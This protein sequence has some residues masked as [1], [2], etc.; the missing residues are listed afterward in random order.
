MVLLDSDVMVDRLRQDAPALAGLDTLGDDE[1]LLPGFVAMEL[2]QGCTHR[3]GRAHLEKALAP[4]TVVWP[5]PAVC[6]EA[7]WCSRG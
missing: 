2:V 6:D 4:F 3:A 5:T 7:F 1:I